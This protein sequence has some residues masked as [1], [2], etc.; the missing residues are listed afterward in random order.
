M[1]HVLLLEANKYY[2]SKG[3]S[4]DS[5]EIIKTYAKGKDSVPWV[6]KYKPIKVVEIIKQLHED[7]E[8]FITIHYMK[9]YRIDDVRSSIYNEIIL[10]TA[11]KASLEKEITAFNYI[12]KYQSYNYL[13]LFVETVENNLYKFL[14]S[15]MYKLSQNKYSI[16]DEE[17][18]RLNELYKKI[19]E[20]ENNIELTNG[21]Y[22]GS[23]EP[24]ERKY[25]DLLSLY[26]NK[27]LM[28]VLYYDDDDNVCSISKKNLFDGLYSI[29]KKIGFSCK[30]RSVLLINLIDYNISK[31]KE[32]Y[33]LTKN[34]IN[35][36]NLNIINYTIIGLTEE[37]ITQLID[38]CSVLKCTYV[39]CTYDCQYDPP[40]YD[41]DN[42]Y[43]NAYDN[44]YTC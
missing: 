35:L 27:Q 2:I 39:C 40:P 1:I 30:K 20:L 23:I 7:N 14:T 32:L 21:L 44:A 29:G 13:P 36:S 15:D 18:F 37:K 28:A 11:T 12:D 33:E 5:E 24:Y 10:N 16:I 4:S 31:K 26:K 41:F 25:I 42:A 3:K 38:M 6:K 19:N 43:A 8:Y 17:L 9:K 34:E 22:Y